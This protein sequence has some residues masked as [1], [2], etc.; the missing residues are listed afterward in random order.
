MNSTGK[1]SSFIKACF[2]MTS[3]LCLSVWGR[4]HVIRTY[5]AGLNYCVLQGVKSQ[6]L[7]SSVCVGGGLL[8]Q[9]SIAAKLKDVFNLKY[10]S[11]QNAQC[12][13]GL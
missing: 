2:A 9:T 1:N 8:V 7:L 11:N 5:S 13:P 3:V 12:I 4:G 6:F 10:N